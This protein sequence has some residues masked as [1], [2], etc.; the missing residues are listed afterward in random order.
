M[1]PPANTV[2]VVAYVEPRRGRLT[3]AEL[4]RATVQRAVAAGRKN[5]PA[6]GVRAYER[7]EKAAF[8]ELLDAIWIHG[9]ATEMGLGFTPEEVSREVALLVEQAFDGPAEY[10]RFRKETRFTRRDVRERVEVQ[11]LAAAIQRK[12]ERGARNEAERAKAFREFIAAYTERWRSRT[13]CAADYLDERCSNGPP[14]AG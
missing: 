13:V 12:I 10:R 11:M 2:A 1:E 4:R 5:L 3:K 6:P 14:P 7:F 8:E 9:Q